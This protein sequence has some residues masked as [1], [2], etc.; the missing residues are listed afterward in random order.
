M[1]STAHPSPD[2]LRIGLQKSGRLS[3]DS[4]HLLDRCGIKIRKHRDRLFQHS[5]NFPL[6]VLLV[7]DDDIPELVMDGICDIGIVGTNVLHEKALKR[8]QQGIDDG[9]ETLHTLNFGGCR[10][11]IAVPEQLEYVD[12]NCLAGKRVATTYP[13]LL[14]QFCAEQNVDMKAIMLNGSVEIAPRLGI[15]DAV[16]DLV[17]TGATLQANGL[18]EVETV[19]TS[20][21]VMVKNQHEWPVE[22]QATAAL[23]ERR[24]EGV[25]QANESK[26]IMLHSSKASLE[27]VIDL[28]PGVEHPTI[29][30]LEKNNDAV[31]IHAVCHETV[32]WNT[33]EKLKAAGASSIL[34]LPI[35]KM[36][37]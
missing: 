22:K 34:V 35:E 4:L 16:C 19:F 11:S 33:M 37:L 6:D 5:E 27:K 28:L 9:I 23:L 32:F 2:R 29:V 7:R 36:M 20:Q 10:L 13:Y 18:R 1:T 15:A 17:S 30:P 14:Q 21:A 12:I 31:A 26:Y 8:N 25:L 24:L 3:D